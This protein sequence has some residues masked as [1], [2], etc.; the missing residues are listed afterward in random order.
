MNNV[1]ESKT[2]QSIFNNEIQSFQFSKA[3]FRETVIFFFTNCKSLTDYKHADLSLNS[4]QRSIVEQIFNHV[5]SHKKRMYENK[6]DQLF[7]YVKNENKTNK[8]R[9]I[10]NL[11]INLIY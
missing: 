8:N 6:D 9:V 3:F 10:R 2:L 5:I 1:N 4:F 11:K 7:L